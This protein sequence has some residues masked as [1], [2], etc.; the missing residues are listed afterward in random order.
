MARF[1]T[2]VG[3]HRLLDR[4]ELTADVDE[5]VGH[6]RAVDLV[7]EDAGGA[8]AREERIPLRQRCE[9]PVERGERRPVIGGELRRRGHEQQIRRRGREQLPQRLE[10]S[11][12]YA[13]GAVGKVDGG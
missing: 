9:Q 10:S 13:R 1:L 11:D 5:Q 7:G 8:Q 4:A 3:R 6:Q 12:R 2:G